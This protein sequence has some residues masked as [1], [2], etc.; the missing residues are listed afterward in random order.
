[1]TKVKTDQKLYPEIEKS[2]GQ[3]KGVLIKGLTKVQVTI[4]FT[5]KYRYK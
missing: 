5:F 3:F 1:M 4:K 2:T